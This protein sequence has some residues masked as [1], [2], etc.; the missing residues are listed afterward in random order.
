MR[1][2]TKGALAAGAGGLLLLGGAG[3]LA[4]WSDTT[5]VDGGDITTGHLRITDA[6]TCSG[7]TLDADEDAASA[8][9]DPATDTLVPGDVISRTCDVVLEAA[10][11][12][13]RATVTA[14]PGTSTDLFTATPGLTLAVAQ[15]AASS[16]GGVTPFVTLSPQEVTE[17]NDGDTLRVTTTVTF[18]AA[19]QDPATTQDITS[20]LADIALTVTQ[21]HD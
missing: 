12:H 13:L 11:E 4:Y 6:E 18:S 17:A 21:V 3:T 7:W 10:G 9:F 19:A 8:A 16:D 14:T 5:T 20:A 1:K 2:T 15:V